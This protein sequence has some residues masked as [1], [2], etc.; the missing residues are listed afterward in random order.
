MLSNGV[1]D[2]SEKAT[3]DSLRAK[4]PNRK[5]QLPPSVPK[6]TPVDSID[7]RSVFMNLKAGVAPGTG[8]CRPEFLSVLTEVWEE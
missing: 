8:G 3:K 7:L 4:Y 2:I 1:A 6:G 5:F